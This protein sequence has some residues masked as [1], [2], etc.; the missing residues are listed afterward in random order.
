MNRGAKHGGEDQ[1]VFAP[2]LPGA[3]A[4]FVDEAVVDQIHFLK[5]LTDW[6]TWYNQERPHYALGLLIPNQYL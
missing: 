3:L 1:P 6:L 2:F 5:R 4:L